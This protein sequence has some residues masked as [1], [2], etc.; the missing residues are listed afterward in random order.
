MPNQYNF[1]IHHRQSMRLKGYDYSLPGAYFVSIVTENRECLFGD[2]TDNRMKLNGAGEIVEQ[3]WLDLP[4]HYPML[5]LDLYVVMPNHIH[6]ILCI[7][8]KENLSN[9]G[10][11]KNPSLGNIIRSF[12]SI[13]AIN[14]NK[15]LNR[16]GQSV[17]QRNY[18]DHII[19][20]EQDLNGR[21]QYIIDNPAR[22]EEDE[23]NK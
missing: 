15:I 13:S 21:R 23:E 20:D 7:I 22:W 6:G 3:V 8:E 2:I 10:K 14:I 18:H 11:E 5:E 4:K 9:E 16:Q 17:W 1:D 19:R 12:K